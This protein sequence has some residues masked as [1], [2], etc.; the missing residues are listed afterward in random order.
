ML[1]CPKKWGKYI[2]YKFVR[3]R[4]YGILSNRNKKEA[5]AAARKA[6]GVEHIATQ[7]IPN[8]R[9]L[10]ENLYS[11]YCSCCHKVTAHLLIDVLPAIRGSPQLDQHLKH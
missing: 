2:P 11:H 6:L 9:T 4:H 7:P 5:L 1:C 10:P 3:I 8:T